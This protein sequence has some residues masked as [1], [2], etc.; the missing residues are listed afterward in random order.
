MDTP[1]L[2]RREFFLIRL[3]DLRKPSWKFLAY[4][5]QMLGNIFQNSWLPYSFL[6]TKKK[7]KFHFAQLTYGMA[8][9]D[10]EQNTFTRKQKATGRRKKHIP[11]TVFATTIMPQEICYS[12]IQR[13]S[14]FSS[15]LQCWKVENNMKSRPNVKINF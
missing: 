8:Y 12:T 3:T 4:I 1:N 14:L 11:I 10:M 6:L 7:R 9:M 5:S 15:Q 2:N 13:G